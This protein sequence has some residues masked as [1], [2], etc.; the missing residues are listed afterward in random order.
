MSYLHE[1]IDDAP[2]VDKPMTA[3]MRYYRK[4][5]SK[6]SEGAKTYYQKN[7]EKIKARRNERYRLSKETKN[8]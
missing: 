6:V 4:N 7:K 2:V 1:L 3:Q 5:T 8:V